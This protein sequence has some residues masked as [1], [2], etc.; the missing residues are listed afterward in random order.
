MASDG[1]KIS[2]LLADYAQEGKP[3]ISLEYFP[4]KTEKG[5]QNLVERMQRMK[6]L[7]P[8]F[9]DFT[10][11]AG[12]SS[13]ELTLDL[14][15]K[16]QNELG[17][18]TNMHLTCT[19]MEVEKI[20]TAL[21][22]CKNG[23]IKNILALRGDP[24]H[25]Q[26][27]WTAAEGGFS[28]ALDL[29]KY[30]RREHGNFFDVSVAGYPE[31]HP[32]KIT[33]VKEGLKSLSE[34]EKRRCRVAP[35][36]EVYV[37]TDADFDAELDYLKAKVDAGATAI[38]TQMFFDVQVY[39]DFVTACRN[40]GINVPILPGIICIN[41]Y[42]GFVRMTDFCKT[43]VPEA[44]MNALNAAKDSA[45][46]VKAVGISY[47]AELCQKLLEAG[48]PGLHFYTLNL[49][50]VCIGILEK[51]NMLGNYVKK[52]EHPK[53]I[54]CVNKLEPGWISFEY[55]PP[56]SETGVQNLY[57]RLHRM[58][59]YKP[60]FADFTWGAGGST[61]DLTLELATRAQTEVGLTSNMHLTCTNMPEEKIFDAL[62]Q[63]KKVGVR[64]IVALR[65]DPPLGQEEWSATEGGFSCAL[66]LVK[67][68]R[69]TYGSYFGISV[70][71]YP[72]GHPNKILEVEGGF[73]SLSESEKKR[74]RIEVDEA[75]GEQKVFVCNDTDF[76]G[77]MEYLKEKIE[78]G[79]DF[80]I[81]QMFL[82]VEVYKTFVEE[83]R[84][85]GIQ[86]PVIPGIICL[87]GYVGLKKMTGFCK[88]RVPDSLWKDLEPIKE[89]ADAMKEYGVQFGTRMCQSLM[90]A[91]APGL[92]FYTLN[93]EKVTLG[94]VNALGKGLPEENVAK[95]L[96][97]LPPTPAPVAGEAVTEVAPPAPPAA[98]LA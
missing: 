69:A 98:Q 77:E 17:M 23:G 94:I 44:L 66:D 88:T 26:E 32:N 11:G 14:C 37:C 50:N 49:E 27:A 45:D 65:G 21:A 46:A 2:E 83:C 91:G 78:A 12:G 1:K 24:P 10:W 57:S 30:I 89:N 53:I 62:A 7:G 25:G 58:K 72:E 42:G 51:L 19:N 68:I 4:P 29:V 15:L 55:F 76:R 33:H 85:Y 39:T 6:E 95:E 5:V 35:D 86:C 40:K 96:A 84:N 8:L 87:N 36:G 67:Y 38:I 52:V 70:A 16:S 71:G 64:N 18:T 48:A 3:W 74:C 13:S 92:H 41:A 34:T 54:D 75:T 61:S 20:Q 80:I 73:E 63:C 60:L 43:R 97:A 82:D 22:G 93:L 59:N 90:E 47:G 56:K 28:C 79:A 31:G 81:T 9:V